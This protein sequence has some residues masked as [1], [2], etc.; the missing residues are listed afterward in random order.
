MSLSLVTLLALAPERG[1]P[2]YHPKNPVEEAGVAAALASLDT[3]GEARTVQLILQ[4]AP[5]LMNLDAEDIAP[6]RDALTAR[7]RE[8]EEDP[9]WAAL[10]S[11]LATAFSDRAPA[12]IVVPPSKPTHRVI[13]FLHGYGGSGKIFSFLLARAIPDAWIVAPSHGVSWAKPKIAYL[14]RALARFEKESGIDPEYHL[15]GLSDGSVGAFEV[16]AKRPHRFRSLTSIVG[17]PKS[18]VVAKLPRIPIL[19]LNGKGDRFVPE[20]AVKRRAPKHA[21]LEWFEGGH[22]FLLDEDALALKRIRA[23]L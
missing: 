6:T 20:A 1:L 21:K 3:L 16:I 9:E 17:I 8:M 22:Y 18:D 23:F 11:P 14:D 4:A 10:P 13:V 19:M 2:V 7:Y 15:V 5:E 12:M